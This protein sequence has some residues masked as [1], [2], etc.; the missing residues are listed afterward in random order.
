MEFFEGGSIG[1]MARAARSVRIASHQ[2]TDILTTKKTLPEA[3]IGAV[4]AQA[5]PALEYGARARP[6]WLIILRYLHAQRKIHRDMKA[7]NLLLNAQGVVKLCDFG[8]PSES[9]PKRDLIAMQASPPL[10]RT[11]RSARRKSARPSGWRPRSSPA[12]ATTNRYALP[13]P[14]F[15]Q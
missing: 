8:T 14:W 13:M 9:Q 6:S 5:L 15:A 7:S 1:G 2:P 3:Q 11:A 12:R 10:L 4:L